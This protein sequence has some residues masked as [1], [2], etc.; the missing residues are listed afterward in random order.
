MPLH[1]GVWEN[2]VFLPDQ[3]GLTADKVMPTMKGAIPGIAQ[4]FDEQH[5]VD[6]KAHG[7]WFFAWN[8]AVDGRV[9]SVELLSTELQATHAA[10]C[11]QGV[12][13]GLEFP[14]HEVAGTEP[15]IMPFKY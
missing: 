6:P 9:T 10:K 12:I 13:K 11:L 3:S 8:V 2:R 15:I 7:K 14:A 4:C 5:R 1:I